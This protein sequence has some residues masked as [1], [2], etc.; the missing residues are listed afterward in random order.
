MN[1]VD[2]RSQIG[3][4][5]GDAYREGA[6]RTASGG[7]RAVFPVGLSEPAGGALAGLVERHLVERSN[8]E[9]RSVGRS[10]GASDADVR[11]VETGFGLGLSALWM[12]LGAERAGL[13][14]WHR[15][16]AIDP[17]QRHAEQMD[18]A[19][20]C[21]CEDAGMWDRVALIEAPSEIALPALV[22]SG[23]RFEIGFVD[24]AHWFENALIDIVMMCRLIVPGGLL[25]VDDQWMGSVRAATEYARLNLN[26]REIERG[27]AG[28][29]RFAAFTVA[30]PDA[31]RAW[32]DWHPFECGA[33]QRRGSAAGAAVGVATR[34][35]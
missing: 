18:G 2:G 33:H 29:D 14:A 27:V 8:G 1:T 20:V 17:G 26:V 24:G 7:M 34:A 5:L 15:H 28:T 12:A 31:G 9:W 4:V 22:G 3:R 10:A 32:D 25:V 35:G 11:T 16:T 23:E 21:L 30:A 19:A 6:V 13:G